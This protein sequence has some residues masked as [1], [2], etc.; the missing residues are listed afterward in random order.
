MRNTSNYYINNSDFYK[1]L[2][3]WHNSGKEQ[4]PNELALAIQQICTNLAKSGKFVGYT[5]KDDMISDAVYMCLKAAKKFNPEKSKNPFSYF[6][7]VAFNA[8]R[9]Y[10]N[11]EHL[12]LATIEA[13][14]RGIETIYDYDLETD[15]D[16]YNSIMENAKSCDALFQKYTNAIKKKKVQKKLTSIDINSL[17]GD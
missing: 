1:I 10:L 5:W 8:F 14:K 4:M 7:Q 17:F 15:E 9:K 12:R 11:T 16:N 2:V 13:Y 3:D 6:T